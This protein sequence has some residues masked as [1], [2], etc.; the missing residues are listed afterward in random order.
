VHED[1][2]VIRSQIADVERVPHED[3]LGPDL[4]LGHAHEIGEALPVLAAWIE[5]RG[6]R[7]LNVNEE[8]ERKRAD[9]DAD[10]AR[11]PDPGSEVDGEASRAA[12]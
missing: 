7:I 5:R 3:A 6:S 10:R 2:R 4:G 12:Q 1:Q 9:G 11:Q 8:G